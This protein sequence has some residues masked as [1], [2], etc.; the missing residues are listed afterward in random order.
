[1]S[2]VKHTPGP[3]TISPSRRSDN[4]CIYARDKDYGIGE[5]WNLSGKP[6][7]KANARLMAAAP[8]MLDALKRLIEP[9][10]GVA[11]LPAWVYGIVKPAIDKAEGRS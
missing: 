3:W 8:D 6:E 1:M 5:A 2:E 7:N 9:T 4:F 10:P 11:K